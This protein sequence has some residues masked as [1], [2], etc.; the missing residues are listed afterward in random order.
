M[1][2]DLDPVLADFQAGAEEVQL[3]GW[4]C[5]PDIAYLACAA[6]P[7]GTPSWPWRGMCLCARRS[8]HVRR[9]CWARTQ[10]GPGGTSFLS[11]LDV[12]ALRGIVRALDARW[13][14][15]HLPPPRI[16]PTSSPRRST[17]CSPLDQ[18]DTAMRCLPTAKERSWAVCEN[19][20]RS[21]FGRPQQRHCVTSQALKVGSAPKT[22]PRDRA[23]S[24]VERAQSARLSR[25][26]GR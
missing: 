12:I 17:N 14:F 5:T 18:T 9:G 26:P 11:S 20:R 2:V 4:H 21:R 22:W 1:S 15:A 8:V 3:P 16:I 23:L 24:S 25:T 19:C 7:T 13:Q 10:G 6:P